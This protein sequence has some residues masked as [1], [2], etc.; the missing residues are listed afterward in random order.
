MSEIKETID[1]QLGGSVS[2]VEQFY[3]KNKRGVQIGAGVLVLAI[4]GFFG[5]TYMNDTKEVEANS[6]LWMMEYYFSKDSFDL[7]LNGNPKAEE[8]IGAIEFVEE[9]SGTKAAQK[10]ALMAGKAYIVKGDY[11]T[12]LTYLEKFR[13]D[14]E[15]IRPMAIGLIGDCHSELGNMEEAESS[16][17]KAANFSSNPYSTPIMLKKL[18][19]VQENLGKHKEAAATYTRIKKEFNE[20]ETA[21]DIE[22]YIARAS[23]KAGINSFDF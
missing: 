23:A 20:S 16:Y 18:G 7:V 5:L 14:D 9:Y 22:K 13:L 2:K 6:R 15:L 19:L 1:E 21:R 10:A 17:Q 8:P 11:T 4:A 3:Q 12:A